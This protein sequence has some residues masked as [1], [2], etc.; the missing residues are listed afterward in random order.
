MT[1]LQAVAAFVHR[2]SGILL[3]EAQ[4]GALAAALKRVDRV[5]D[6]A[7]FM[8]RAADPVEGPAHVARL[9]DE[10]TVKETFFLRAPLQLDEIAWQALFDRARAR[11]AAAVRIWSA[12][13]ATG[14]EPYTLAL[15]ACEAFGAEPPVT[16]FATDISEG[17]LRQARVGD[18]RPRST[19]ELDPSLHRRYFRQEGER[20]VAGDRLRSLVTFAHHNL[21]RDPVPPLG[22]APFDLIL[23]RNVLIYF[24]S[25]TVDRVTAALD[26]ALAPGGT[27]VLGAADALCRSAGRLRSLATAVAPLQPSA[28]PP[29]RILRRPLGRVGG[30]ALTHDHVGIAEAAGS[31]ESGEMISRTTRLLATDPLNA[32]AHFLHGLAELEAGDAAAAVSA[33]RRALYAEPQFGLA[34]FQLGRAYESLGNHGAARRAYE[35]ALRTCDPEGDLHEPLLGQVDLGDVVAAAKTRLDALA[36]IGVSAR[37]ASG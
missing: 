10:V 4:Y 20:L 7:C 32:S 5:G 8:R 37:G 19:R 24:D 21:V 30:P 15:L 31:G 26:R 13:C 14:E 35:Q 29:Q 1:P 23:C 22:E 18:Y 34:A 3:R 9:L 12:A 27:L 33:L 28:T 6:P 36:A 25:E 17:A 11:G 16:I 2:E